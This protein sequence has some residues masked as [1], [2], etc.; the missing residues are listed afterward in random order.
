MHLADRIDAPAGFIARPYRGAEDHADMARVLNAHYADD[1]EDGDEFTAASFD[2]EENPDECDVTTDLVMIEDTTGTTVAYTRTL[3]VEVPSGLD[4]IIHL[5]CEPERLTAELN[6]AVVRAGEAHAVARSPQPD[7]LRI[8]CPHPGPDQAP[9][10]R[11]AWLEALGYETTEWSAALLRPDLDDI[12]E[13]PLPNGVEV[14]PVDESQLRDIVA[15]HHECFRGEWDFTEASERHFEHILG[16][17][18]RDHT[19]WQ[20]A[21]AGDTIVGQVKP[22]IDHKA[23]EQHGRK[24]GYPEH[25]STHRDWRNQGIAGALLARSLRVLRDRGMT[26]A[27]LGVDTSSPGGALHLYTRLGFAPVSFDVVYTKAPVD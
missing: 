26:E 16:D 19:L 14:R 12:P 27:M 3:R 10:G 11:A 13:L 8:H 25:I 5:A 2:R 1:A 22:F 9:T 24:R 18:R 4:C 20:V 6:D 23:N 17:S 7:R 15:A 21:W